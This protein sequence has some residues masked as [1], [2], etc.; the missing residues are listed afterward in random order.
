MNYLKKIIEKITRIEAPDKIKL[1]KTA[2]ATEPVQDN[3]LGLGKWHFG[4][5]I[6]WVG[7]GLGDVHRAPS[8]AVRQKEASVPGGCFCSLVINMYLQ[9][10]I[11]CLQGGGFSKSAPP[12]RPVNGKR[13][14]FSPSCSQQYSIRSDCHILFI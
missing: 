10:C 5:M 4:V 3:C 13:A 11:C 9:L 2:E 1:F 14:G 12:Q 7:E 6:P 8:S